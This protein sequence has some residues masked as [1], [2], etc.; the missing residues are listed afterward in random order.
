MRE[1]FLCATVA[2]MKGRTFTQNEIR[3]I[4]WEILTKISHAIPRS[5]AT[6]V[7]LSGELG[8]GK[9]TLT[10]AIARELGVKENVISP[11]FVLI[12]NYTLTAKS[13]TLLIHI[14]AY[15]FDSASELSKLGWSELLADPN[16]LILIEWP[17][18]VAGLIP[19]DAIRVSLSHKDE[20][21][22]HVDI[23]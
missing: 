12:K 4:A 7:A 2:D 9:T 16:K 20:K 23:S 10:Q 13:Y 17:E 14:D 22:R 1:F 18:R 11:T 6:V 3:E 8:A 5:T 19:K 15:R 21:T